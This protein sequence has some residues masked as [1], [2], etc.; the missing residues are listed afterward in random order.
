MDI[1]KFK[2]TGGPVI[3][4]VFCGYAQGGSYDLVL[5]ERDRNVN[6]WG[7]PKPGTFTNPDDDAYTLPTPNSENDGRI[8]DSYTSIIVWPN[9]NAYHVGL[10]F[11]QGGQRLEP[12]VATDPQG[13]PMP[14]SYAENQ[15]QGST[16]RRD[17]SFRF[18]AKLELVN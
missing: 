5:W 10:R 18:F 13:S 12:I 17:L 1:I 3:V 14:T 15:L 6:V 2:K 16:S 4:E 7:K 8:V 11:F 9:D